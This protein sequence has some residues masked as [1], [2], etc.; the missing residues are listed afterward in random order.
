M[1][2]NTEDARPTDFVII[3]RIVHPEYDPPAVYN[4]IALFRLKDAVKFNEY[5]RPICLHDADKLFNRHLIAT[6]WGALGYGEYST[7]SII[8]GLRLQLRSAHSYR[9]V[10]IKNNI[11]TIIHYSGTQA[12]LRTIS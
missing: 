7:L 9:L 8:V 3:D 12:K 2:S 4:D 5:F 11:N 1:E 6:G 10:D